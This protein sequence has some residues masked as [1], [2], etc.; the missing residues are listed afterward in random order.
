MRVNTNTMMFYDTIT[1]FLIGCAEWRKWKMPW[2]RWIHTR[3][4]APLTTILSV[5]LTNHIPRF[6]RWQFW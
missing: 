2:G 5:Y 4:I 1:T 3:L 6:F